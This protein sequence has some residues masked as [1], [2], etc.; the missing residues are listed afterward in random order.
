MKAFVIYLPTAPKK[1][2][3]VDNIV[4][5]LKGYGLRAEAFV[6]TDGAQAQDQVQQQ[7]LKL[8][9]YS[10]KGQL[11][12]SNNKDWYKLSRPG[13]MGCFLSHYR[14][15]QR[16]AELGEPIMIF[17]DDV[18]LYRGWKPVDWNDILIL[19]LGKKSH[20]KMPWKD[21]LET[22]AG[23]PRAVKW[24]NRSMPGTSGYAIRP[25]MAQRLIDVYKGHWTASDNAINT[26]IGQIQISTYL[27]G[28]HMTGQ[29]GNISL[30]KRTW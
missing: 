17:E 24:D 9:P 7:D 21:Y 14:L 27:M 18:K 30:T 12:N 15:W 4:A 13:V 29:E 25:H 5:Q 1:A 22:P 20:L 6:G 8:W 11:V 16:C 19:S 10:V 28:R 26:D 23:E 3:A 2:I